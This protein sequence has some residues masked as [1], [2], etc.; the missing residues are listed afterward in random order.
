MVKERIGS[1]VIYIIDE[2]DLLWP[3]CRRRGSDQDHTHT[4]KVIAHHDTPTHLSPFSFSFLFFSFL[5]FF[6]RFH[7][8]F[9][10]PMVLCLLHVIIL[11]AKRAVKRLCETRLNA[12]TCIAM[13]S[14]TNTFTDNNRTNFDNADK[15]LMKLAR[16]LLGQKLFV[17]LMKSSFYGH[18]VAGE[19]RHTIV[20][21]L[22]RLTPSPYPRASHA[23][24]Y[25]YIYIYVYPI[26]HVHINGFRRSNSTQKHDG[27][28]FKY[29]L[30]SMLTEQ[31]IE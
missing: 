4:G 5:V 14:L 9:C 1:T 24:Q 30:N 11:A 15:Q 26:L 31:Q 23:S 27:V 25:I 8:A 20:P 2:G 13:E 10:R 19:N 29:W 18:F 3:L 7:I 17:L 6:S 12:H 16:N 28:L 22:E 21:A